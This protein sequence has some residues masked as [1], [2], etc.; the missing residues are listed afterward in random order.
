MKSSIPFTIRNVFQGLAETEGILSANG[1]NLK[2]EFRTTDSVLGLLKSGVQEVKL[3][4]DGI[5]EIA[6]RKGWFGSSVV[7]RV[8]EMR[9]AADVPNSKQ[10]EIL[11]SIAKKHSK[12]A[13]EL[14]SSVTI[15]AR[16]Q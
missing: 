13:A 16:S 14:A 4:I 6:F 8:A 5:Q 7:I 11:L 9:G 15:P 3:P 1:T 12:A 2:L 10:G